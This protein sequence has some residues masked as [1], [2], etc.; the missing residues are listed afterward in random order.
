MSDEKPSTSGLKRVAK[1]EVWWSGPTVLYLDDIDAIYSLFTQVSSSVRLRLDGYELEA[2]ADAAQLKSTETADF[3]IRSTDPYA[4]FEASPGD[5][6]FWVSDRE[7]VVLLGLRDATKEILRK[8]RLWAPESMLPFWLLLV[9]SWLLWLIPKGPL[10][11]PAV[12]VGIVGTALFAGA[13][14]VSGRNRYRRGGKVIL[15]DSRSKPSFRQQNRDLFLV[16]LT[17]VGTLLATVAGGVILFA[18]GFVGKS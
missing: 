10:V 15:R 8:R 4:A 18:L 2:P 17:I 12:F 7:N 16:L 9:P 5:F 13:H 3:E 6:H 1:G 14:I 11:L